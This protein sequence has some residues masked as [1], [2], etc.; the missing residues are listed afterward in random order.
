MYLF[1]ANESTYSI[2]YFCRT[3]IN[4]AIQIYSLSTNK[5]TKHKKYLFSNKIKLSLSFPVPR[6]KYFSIKFVHRRTDRPISEN[7]YSTQNNNNII[8][9]SLQ[10]VRIYYIIIFH[11][12]KPSKFYMFS[13]CKFYMFT[14]FIVFLIVESNLINNLLRGY[15]K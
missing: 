15:I 13:N 6:L 9:I 1:I 7:K 12:R 4:T 11:H 2:T 14:Y 3:W 5:C 10:D 8:W